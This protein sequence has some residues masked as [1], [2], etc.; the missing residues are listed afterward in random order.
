[1]YVTRWENKRGPMPWPLG[2]HDAGRCNQATASSSTRYLS[3]IRIF[4]A[5]CII[6]CKMMQFLCRM[7]TMQVATA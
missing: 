1:M 5:F 2:K 3:G 4:C 7:H 6:R